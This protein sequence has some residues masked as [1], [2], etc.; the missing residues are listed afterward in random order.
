MPLSFK[1]ENH[2]NIAF[3]Y[4][5]IESDLLLLENHLFFADMFCEWMSELADQKDLGSEKFTRQV[6]LIP[7][8][9]NI[10]DLMGAIHAVSYTGFIGEIY[11]LFPF[12]EE[13]EDFKQNPEGFNTQEIVR[14]KIQ[15]F[16]DMTDLSVIFEAVSN[17]NGKVH[18]GPYVFEKK[19]FHE[20]IRYVE[21][22]GYPEWKDQVR[23]KYVID[24]KDHVQQSCNTFFKGV[25]S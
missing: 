25:F 1:S 8:P 11:K 23:P 21:K 19:V 7:D 4:F 15:P 24:M 13:D 10:G 6:Y 18:I 22:G 14:T 17:E 9:E 12:P 16:S 3:G 2:G 20:L 5:N